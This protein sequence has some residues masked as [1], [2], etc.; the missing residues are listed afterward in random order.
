M[1]VHIFKRRINYDYYIPASARTRLNTDFA[2]QLNYG[3]FQDH[4]SWR[5]I[6]GEITFRQGSGPEEETL[7]I[8]GDF[9][10]YPLL[11][12][13]QENLPQSG[14]KTGM[15]KP[16][17]SQLVFNVD[18]DGLLT[19]SQESGTPSVTFNKNDG[20]VLPTGTS[21]QRGPDV[22]GTLR[23][24][25]T[26]DNL[27]LRTSTEWRPIV[28]SEL[29]ELNGSLSPSSWN[30]LTATASRTIKYAQLIHRNGPTTYLNVNPHIN[31]YQVIWF[32]DNIIVQY[33]GNDVGFYD[34]SG[35]VDQSNAD[36]YVFVSY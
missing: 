13:M 35:N 11:H 7:V 26:L 28:Q 36:L 33:Q 10:S 23:F 15:Q 34:S 18:S 9:D 30:T 25:T 12:E 32:G 2:S 1:A 19:L 27:E 5:G 4:K 6:E 29:I 22:T 24:N 8:H 17:N 21:A 3:S 14:V 16:N 31:S 20:I